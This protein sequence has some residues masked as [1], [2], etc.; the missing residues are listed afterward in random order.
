[1][2][3][4]RDCVYV[5]II[6][7]F[8]K[9]ELTPLCDFDLQMLIMKF[10]RPRCTAS[11]WSSGKVTMT[12]ATTESEAKVGARRCARTLQK[13]GFNVRFTNYRIVNVLATCTMP[14]AIKIAEF[15][16]AHPRLARYAFLL[17]F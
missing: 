12:G 14:F 11:I 15:A 13:L 2:K 7:E 1:M 4:L 9:M 8:C 6:R 10:R 17:C 3:G 5:F 16:S